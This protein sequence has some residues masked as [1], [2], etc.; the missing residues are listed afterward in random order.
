LFPRVPLMP[1]MQAMA[2]LTLDEA[3]SLAAEACSRLTRESFKEEVRDHIAAGTL[4]AFGFPFFMIWLG[5]AGDIGSLPVGHFSKSTSRARVEIPPLAIADYGGPDYDGV[6]ARGKGPWGSGNGWEDV[7][8]LASD[9]KRLWPRDAPNHGERGAYD[10]GER[11][12]SVLKKCFPHGIPSPQGLPNGELVRHVQAKHKEFFEKGTAPSRKTILKHAGRIF[13]KMACFWEFGNFRNSRNSLSITRETRLSGR[14]PLNNRV[15]K[16][17]YLVD[18]SG[19][20]T[21]EAVCL[22]GERC[23]TR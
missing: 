8:L 17:V 10:S 9:V 5:H 16:N 6:I 15:A 4:R 23:R 14:F 22:P 2:F 18:R 7:R 13:Q 20:E 12:K 3:F 19:I 1:R 21:R 11:T